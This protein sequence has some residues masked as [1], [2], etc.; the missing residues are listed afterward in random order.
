MINPSQP[1][2]QALEVQLARSLRI[3]L[4]PQLL[5][6]L[7]ALI[8]GLDELALELRLHSGDH[9]RDRHGERSWHVESGQRDGPRKDALNREKG[10]EC[11]ASEGI[12]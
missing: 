3:Q 6:S 2:L 10:E 4:E 7:I 1:T 9:F 5:H 11:P 12:L 8:L